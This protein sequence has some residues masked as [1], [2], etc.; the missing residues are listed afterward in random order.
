MSKIY[1]FSGLGVDKRV[2]H[3]IDFSN[4]NAVFVDW[5]DPLKKES[6]ETDSFY[7]GLLGF[8]QYTRPAV[9][10]GM[11]V[12][13]V[14]SS[15]HHKKIDEYRLLESLRKTYKNRPDLLE[16]KLEDKEFQKIWLKYKKEA[17]K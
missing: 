4:L 17:E 1:I 6:F 5:I 13:E 10:E 8:P 15:G 3:K 7:N 16:K 12:P 14:L 11:E 9:I 2:F